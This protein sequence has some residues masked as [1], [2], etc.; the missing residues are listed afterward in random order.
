[1]EW[2]VIY[3]SKR[4]DD[5]VALKSRGGKMFRIIVFLFVLSACGKDKAASPTAPAAPPPVA[6]STPAPTTR[7]PANIVFEGGYEC[8]DRFCDIATYSLRVTNTG[9]VGA[10]L[11]YLRGENRN[12]TPIWEYGADQIIQYFGTNRLE[13]RET[14]E[15]LVPAQLGAFVVLGYTDDL[16]NNGEVVLIVVQ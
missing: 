7:Q 13:V 6:T 14:K 2:G 8:T 5:P 15:A 4:P 12:A 16:R 10:N 1:M 11:N 3:F 9:G